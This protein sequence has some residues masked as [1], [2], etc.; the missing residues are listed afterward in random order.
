MVEYHLRNRCGEAEVLTLATQQSLWRSL[1]SLGTLISGLIAVAVWSQEYDWTTGLYLVLLLYLHEVGHVLAA[2][3]RKVRVTRPPV[4]LPGLGAVVGVG[5]GTTRL[6][7]VL[8]LLGGS[9][10]GGAAS[11][12]VRQIGLAL[13][14][15]ALAFAGDVT[16]LVNLLNLAPIRPLDGGRVA[17]MAGWLGLV[18]AVGVLVY[19]VL[20]DQWVLRAGAVVVLVAAVAQRFDRHQAETWR[21]RLMALGLW[22]GAAALLAAPLMMTD[23]LPFL[24]AVPQPF[25]KA[26]RL[27]PWSCWGLSCWASIFGARPGP[28]SGPPSSATSCSRLGVG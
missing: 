18:P 20:A 25:Q 28:G 24:H 13:G 27:S 1:F 17:Q 12:A 22:L 10:V 5:Q 4:F 6:D 14:Q 11:L 3:W 15:P 19:A 26:A 2:L 21:E 7:E 23:R 8:V 16:L 9:V